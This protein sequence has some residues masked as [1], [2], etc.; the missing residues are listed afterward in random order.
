[1]GK[2]TYIINSTQNHSAAN[3]CRK[4]VYNAHVLA[5]AHMLKW[6]HTDDISSFEG[7]TSGESGIIL[8]Y[9][10]ERNSK[11]YIIIRKTSGI[12]N[13]Q[14]EYESD[15][16]TAKQPDRNDYEQITMKYFA[17]RFDGDETNSGKHFP[18][19]DGDV[20]KVCN[21]KINPENLKPYRENSSYR[22]ISMS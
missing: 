17:C 16:E 21:Y 22:R 8:K 7:Y 2:S 4:E 14:T 11:G 6:N 13:S 1:M 5:M 15:G 12:D 20:C 9:F 18:E 10:F 19:W 3:C